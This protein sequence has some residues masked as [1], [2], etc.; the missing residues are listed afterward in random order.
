MWLRMRLTVVFLLCFGLLFSQTKKSEKADS[1]SHYLQLA[2]FNSEVNNFKNSLD[3]TQKAIDYA[4]ANNDVVAEAGALTAL[5][6]YYFELK[7]YDDA[8]EIFK[9]SIGLYST[10]QPSDAQAYAYYNLG[11][12]YMEKENYSQAEVSFNQAKSIYEA[13]KIPDAIDELNLQK[14]IVYKAKGK[15]KQASTIFSSLIARP[16]TQETTAVKAEALYQMG[17]IEAEQG[18]N[19]L[20][21]NYM[22]RALELNNLARNIDLESKIYKSMSA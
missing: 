11:R 14:G 5:G 9:K 3:F 15:Y 20:A 7:K 13:I 17:T 6:T 18:R 10:Q 12:S 8:I 4:H 2:K 1:V 16:E 19:N 22:H 21:V